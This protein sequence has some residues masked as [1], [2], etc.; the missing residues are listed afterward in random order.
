MLTKVFGEYLRKT[1]KDVLNNNARERRKPGASRKST[2]TALPQT[3]V[4]TG[5]PSS[6]DGAQPR[7]ALVLSSEACGLLR[8]TWTFREFGALLLCTPSCLVGRVLLLGKNRKLQ[9][10]RSE[11]A[12]HKVSIVSSPASIVISCDSGGS[13]Q[14]IYRGWCPLQLPV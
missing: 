10:Q 2:C 6:S 5:S 12:K 4:R 14:G 7:G 1:G 8:K 13:V 9:R 3:A 11:D